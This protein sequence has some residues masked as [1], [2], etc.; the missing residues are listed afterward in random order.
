MDDEIE[1]E[2]S[3]LSREIVRDGVTVDI[4]I[5]RGSDDEAW[6]LEVV[7]ERNTSI[8]WDE[9]FPT[10]QAALNEALREIEEEGIAVFLDP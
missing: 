4:R 2:N 6:L 10:D 5:Y 1:I 7:N 8:V 9:Q 3:P